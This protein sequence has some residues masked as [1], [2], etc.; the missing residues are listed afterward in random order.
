[1][2]RARRARC[3]GLRARAASI[4]LL[5]LGAVLSCPGIRANAET[6]ARPASLNF[7]GVPGLLDMPTGEAAPDAQFAWTNSTFA[8][9]VRSTLSFQLT[10]RVGGSF[11]YTGIENWHFQGYATYYDR[12]FDLRYRLIDEGR[13]LPAVTIGLQ[14]FIGTGLFSAE[15]VAA[16]KSLTPRL[17]VTAGLGWGRL[18]SDG[19]IG[20]PFGPRP[21]FVIGTGGRPNFGQWF[22]GPA[23]PFGGVEWQATDKLTFKLEY[24]SDAYAIEAGA[25]KIFRR[26][27]PWNFGAEYQVTPSLRFGLAYL[28]GSELG[29]NLQLALDPK[30]RPRDTAIQGPAPA[31]V[32]ARPNRA[33]SPQDYA[34]DWVAVPQAR[35]AI[36]GVLSKLLEADGMDLLA[37]T[38]RGDRAEVRIQNRLYDSEA[39]AVGRTAR[40]LTQVLP[41][42]VDTFDI[43][44]VT[45]GLPISKITIRRDALEQAEL[46]P[47]GAALLRQSVTLSDTGPLAPGEHFVPGRYPLFKWSFLPYLQFSFFDP[48]HPVRTEGGLRLRASYEIR[49]GLIFSGILSKKLAGNIDKSRT[50]GSALPHVRTDAALYAAD[51]G[52]RVD[53]LTMA[54]LARPG[55]NLYSR[56]TLG[57]L[58]SMYGG[59]SAEVLWKPVESRLAL[60]AEVNLV[61]QR[62]PGRIF[63]FRDYQ[64]ATGHLLA[65]YDLGKG[66]EAQLAVGRY[67]AGDVGATIS[68][69]RIFPSG[70]RLGAFATFTDVSA[71]EFGEGSF[72]KG[73]RLTI[74]LNWVTGQPSRRVYGTVIRSLT[75]DGGAR[76]IVADRLYPMVQS[77]HKSGLDS[78]W[79]RV[80]R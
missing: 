51:N 79:G 52:I 54:W 33:S 30:S 15:Y 74:P 60:G 17:K 55:H 44:P 34:T 38:L 78:Q 62:E 7:N 31:P 37:L 3:G 46:R 71:A 18:G 68:L 26:E 32:K 24:S 40:L 29:L 45:L 80:L 53:Q 67:L 25:R 64:V 2:S 14:D 23:A 69:D 6:T 13:Y 59:V 41:A 56:V 20:E 16:T 47:D 76:L 77:Y 57:Y 66:Y 42:S 50:Y 72:D 49:P 27:S 4:G 58:E 43:V 70:W 36:E 10:P 65:Y 21:G 12:S 73:I 5:M 28:Y 61:R 22:R 63:A 19:A 35:S 75:R 11:R 48:S 39:Q 9:T 8:R 1:M